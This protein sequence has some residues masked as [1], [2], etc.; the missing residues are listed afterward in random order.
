MVLQAIT[1]QVAMDVVPGSIPSVLRAKLGVS[2]SP[3]LFVHLEGVS[4]VTPQTMNPLP[5]EEHTPS[6][7]TDVSLTWNFG[8]LWSVMRYSKNP[9]V[10][11]SRLTRVGLPMLP[12]ISRKAYESCH[13][14]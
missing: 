10:P 14:E 4:T 2:T 1:P 9:V 7:G 8:E 12:S 3:R 5:G 6:A 13:Q 11:A